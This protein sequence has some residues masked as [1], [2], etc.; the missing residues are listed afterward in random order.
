[1]KK[2]K[3]QYEIEK[4]IR[5]EWKINPVER[6]VESKKKYSR[7]RAKKEQEEQEYNYW[8]ENTRTYRDN[9]DF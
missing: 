9:E 5:R 4:S 2:K 1:M 6:T 8:N 7:R 3:S